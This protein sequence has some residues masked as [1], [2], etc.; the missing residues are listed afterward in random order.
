MVDTA[1]QRRR[2]LTTNAGSLP[3]P[4]ALVELLMSQSAARPSCGGTDSRVDDANRHVVELSRRRLA[5]ARRRPGPRASYL[6]EH[7]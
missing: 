1:M 3:R 7:R 5:S 4:A 6:R 2:I